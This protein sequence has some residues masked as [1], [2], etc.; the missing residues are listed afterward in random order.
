[1]LLKAKSN[2]YNKVTKNM[3]ERLLKI[4]EMDEESIEKL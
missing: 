1:M 2:D 4:I 3:V